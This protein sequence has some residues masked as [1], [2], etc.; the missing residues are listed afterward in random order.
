[1]IRVLIPY[2]RTLYYNDKGRERG[3]AVELVRD[4]ERYL[5]KKH[6]R[7]L[8]KRPITVIVIP[9]T[10]DV[11]I[12]DVAKGLGDIAAGNLTETGSRLKRVD[13]VA[14]GTASRSASWW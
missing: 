7:K 11:L 10:R 14:P 12:E 4:F 6:A 9:V 13:F 5:N 3:I 2:S 1:M 8:Q